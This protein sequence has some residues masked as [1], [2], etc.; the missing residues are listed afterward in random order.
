MVKE[1]LNEYLTTSELWEVFDEIKSQIGA[2]ELL[3]NLAQAMG[4][5]ELRE[6]LEYIA[7]MWDL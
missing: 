7:R 4:T 2:D 3:D 6:N 1:K 5:D